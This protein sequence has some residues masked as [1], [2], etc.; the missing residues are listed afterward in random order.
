MNV[1]QLYSIVFGGLILLYPLLRTARLFVQ[2]VLPRLAVGFVR[3]VR[4]PIVLKRRGWMSV[5]RLELIMFICYLVSNAVPL[6]LSLRSVEDFQRRAA[7]IAVINLTPLFLGGRTNPFVDLLGVPLPTYYLC[8]H[9]IGR[10]AVVES[11]VHAIYMLTRSRND[12]VTVSGY[13]VSSPSCF[14]GSAWC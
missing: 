14:R 3:H 7:V 6:C 4:Y 1:I 12:H 9:W 13:V 11:L 8:H 5:T 2:L 10:V